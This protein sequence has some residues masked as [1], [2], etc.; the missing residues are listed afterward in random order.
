MDST[1]RESNLY[2]PSDPSF[3]PIL[4]LKTMVLKSNYE[5][6]VFSNGQW[7]CA[8]NKKANWNTSKQPHSKG[9]KC[10]PFQSRD[11]LRRLT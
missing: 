6:G 8:C 10:E 11:Q 1:V 3:S 2:L 5:I 4:R 9:E 7:I